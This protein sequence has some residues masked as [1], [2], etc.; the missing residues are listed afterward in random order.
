MDNNCEEWLIEVWNTTLI[1]Y[2]DETNE[3]LKKMYENTLEY[4]LS[5]NYKHQ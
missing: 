5:L 2:L 1:R 3:I 4:L